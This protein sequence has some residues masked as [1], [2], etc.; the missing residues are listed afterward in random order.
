[1]DFMKKALLSILVISLLAIVPVMAAVNVTWEWLLDDPDVKYFRYQLEGEVEDAWTVVPSDTT[2]Y[3]LTEVD[4]S[5]VY[6]LYLQQ[7]Y[8]GKNWSPSS[9][10]SS[11]PVEDFAA[12]EVAEAV[13]PEV[14]S[15]PIEETF[16]LEEPAVVED[17]TALA[18]PVAAPVEEEVVES[19]SVE[20]EKVEETVEPVVAPAGEDEVK[21]AVSPAV[22]PQN[23]ANEFK[24]SLTLGSAFVYK[25]NPPLAVASGYGI[26]LNAG[27]M[28]ENIV[29]IG[30]NSGLGFSFDAF[31]ILDEAKQQADFADYLKLS[32]YSKILGGDGLLIYSSSLG[33]AKFN[34]GAGA[35]L[36]ISSVSNAYKDYEFTLFNKN[37]GWTYNLVGMAQMRYQFNKAFSMGVEAR[38]AYSLTKRINEL[39][40]LVMMG[41]SF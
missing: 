13:V 9:V 22:T 38:Y 6:T 8:D 18:E 33:K 35:D 29:K 12:E 2:T 40:G 31:A 21:E 34:L 17:T 37:I 16:A 3:E 11:T 1:M 39:S 7:S 41:F 19:V 15:A 27:L 23:K 25:L 26:R 36:R 10:A 24:F 4:G 30:K 5:V 32:N 28:L 20:E 14:E